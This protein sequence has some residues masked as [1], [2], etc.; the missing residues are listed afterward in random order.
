MDQVVHEQVSPR[1]S[2][3][4]VALLI[5]VLLILLWPLGIVIRGGFATAPG[6]PLSSIIPPDTLSD[7]VSATAAEFRVSES[8]AATYS[9]PLH[10]VPGTAGV[11]PKLSLTYS[12][13]GG[14]GSIAKGWAIGGMSAITRC[15]ASREAGDF[16][17][18]GLVVDG[19]PAP[20]NYTATD[21]YCLDGARLLTTADT[22][23][24]AVAGMAGQA[25]FTE[26]QTYRRVCAYTPAGGASGVAFFTVDGR[27]GSLSWYGDRD[28][29]ASANRPDAYVNSTASGKEAFALVWA[30]TRFQDST[31][32]YIDYVYHEGSAA[33]G[34]Q[35]EHLIAKV[36]YT[37]KIALSGQTGAAQA[38]YAEVE[39]NYDNGGQFFGIERRA[40]VAGGLIRSTSLLASITSRVD[41]DYNGV[42]TTVRHY[43]LTYA[44]AH[45]AHRVLKTLQECRDSDLA[46]CSAPTTFDWSTPRE[47]LSG[48][49]NLF[50]TFEQT[51]SVP[52]GSLT[53]FEGLK[54]GDIDGDGRQDM[55][56]LKDGSSGDTCPSKSVNLLYSRLDGSGSPTL[57]NAGTV[58]CAPNGLYWKPQDHSWF[59]LDYNGDGRD[60]YFQRTDTAWIG[61]PATGNP[62]QPFDTGVNLLAE[63]THPIPSGG[64]KYSEPQ[65]ADLNGDGLVDLVYPANGSLVARIMERGGSHG[66]RWG[67][68]RTVSLLGNDC[69]G[70]GCYSAIGL[71]RKSNY[72]Q[73]NDFNADAR[74]DLIVNVPVTC[75]PGGGGGPGDGPPGGGGHV[76]KVGAA[77]S[78]SDEQ[79]EVATTQNTSGSC[80]NGLFFAV[81]S[82]TSNAVVLRRFAEGKALDDDSIYSFSDVNG[83][84]ASDLIY[85]GNPATSLGMMYVEL[86]TG[87]GFVSNGQNAIQIPNFQHAQVV[88][89]NGDGRADYVYPDSNGNMIA[90]HGYPSGAFGGNIVLGPTLLGCTSQ[91]CLASRSHMFVD[92]EGDGNVDYMRV[93]WD[94]DSS[95]PVTFS[96]GSV[97]NRFVPRSTLLRVT[98]GLG[99][100]TEISYAPLTLK[101]VY[102]PDN[103]SR[104][105]L[106]NWGRGAPVQDVFG[107]MYV[108]HKVS[109]SAPQNGDSAAKS[110]LHYRYNGAKMQSGGRGF[111]GFRELVTI[112]PNQTGGYV[113]TSSEYAQ[114]FPYTGLPVKTVKR[115]AINMAYVPSS[116][117]TTAPLDGCFAPRHQPGAGLTGTMFSQS[118]QLWSGV[119]DQLTST[120]AFVPGQQGVIAVRASGAEELTVDPFNNIQ[121]GRV[122]TT[123]SYGGYGNVSQTTV[124]T[125]EG[126]STSPMS[127]VVNGN[128]YLDDPAKWRLGRLSASTVT[129]KRP[130]MPDVVRSTAFSYAMTGPVTGLLNEER[131]QPNG[132]VRED[133]RKAYVLDDYGNRIASF[134]CTQQVAD[135]RS[136]NIQY[137]MWQWERV[138]RYG[139]QEFDSRGRFP[140]KTYELFRPNDTATQPAEFVT[141][142]VVDRDEYGNATE[143]VGL[144]NVRAFARFGV[145]GRP[146][147]A[148]KQSDPGNAAPNAS[149]TVGIVSKTTFRWCNTGS[150]AVTCPA[151]LKFRSKTVASGTPT[152]WVYYDVL[153]REV[154][155]ASQTFNAGVAGKDVGA[156]CTEYDA[157][158]RPARVST[159]FF[160]A[161]TSASGEPD[162][163]DGVCNSSSRTWA[164]TEYDVLGRPVRV[165]EPNNAISTVAYSGTTTTSTNARSFTKVEIK[166]ARG[167]LIQAGDNA[168]LNTFYAYDA[169]GNLGAV[170]RDAGRGAITTS[171]GYD[172]LGRKTYVNDPDG[173]VLNLAYSAAGELTDEW[174]PEGNVNFN[175]YDFRG[176]VAWKGSIAQ[177]PAGQVWDHSASTNFDTA[178]NGLGQEHCSWTDPGIAYGTWQ[179]Q[180][181]KKQVWSRCNSYDAMGRIIGTA[182]YVDG[183]SYPSA[184]VYDLLGR[185]QKAQDPSGKWLKTEF[186]LRGQALR[187][188][189]SSSADSAASCAPGVATTYLENQEADA[190][191]NIVKDVRGGSAAMQQFRQYDPLTGRLSEICAGNS[192]TDCAIMRDRYVWD[193]VGNMV[194]RDR[195]DYGE[196]FWYD[197]VDRL[198]ISRINRVGSTSYGYGTGQVTDWQ[199]FDKL[200]NVCAHF[201]R[202]NDATWMNYNGRAGCGLN[203]ETGTV[204]S[205]MT[206]SP[207]QVRQA[208]AYSNFVYDSR[209]NQVFADSS[210]SDSLDRTIRYN[211]ESQAY[212]IFKGPSSAPN[213]MARFWYDPSGNRYKREDTGLGIVGTRR[214]IYVGNIEIVSENGT[215]TYKRYIGGVLVQDVVGGNPTNRYLFADHIGSVVAVTDQNGVVVEG[216][217]FNA[218][219]E[220]RG[221][222]SATTIT[223]NGLASTTRGFTGH[224]M[225]DGLD[226]IHMNGRI[227]DPTLGRFLQPDPVIQDTAN[228]QN[229][230]AY[231]YVFNNPYRY[232]DP[233]GMI[234]QEERR[235]LSMIVA[236]AVSWFAPQVGA[237]LA[238]SA[239]AANAIT[240]ALVVAGGAV[241]GGIS[242]GSQGALAGAFS[243]LAFYSVGQ[244]FA[245]V[246]GA[247]GTGFMDSGF[248]TGHFAA[249]VISHGMLSGVLSTVQGGKFGHGFVSAA[250][251]ASV[252]PIA[253]QA[254]LLGG[255]IISAIVGGTASALTGG[256]FASG[257]ATAIFSFVFN[258]WLHRFHTSESGEEAHRYNK[259]KEEEKVYWPTGNGAITSKYGMRVHPRTGILKLHNGLDIR[260]RHGAPIFATQNGEIILINYT[261]GGG[262]QIFIR[263]DD[264]GIS[265]Y[266][267]TGAIEGIVEGV[268]VSGGQQIGVSNSSGWARGAAHL[269]YTYKPGTDSNPAT[270]KTPTVSPWAQLGRAVRPPVLP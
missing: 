31:G 193:G 7:S 138:H 30:Q 213:R 150:G 50:Q 185:A 201:M 51:A 237:A 124:D 112:D 24:P 147:Y 259:V 110:T 229:W 88:D 167:E 104:N 96:R 40:Y 22:Q 81:E 115:A 187:V 250:A 77:S 107:P 133:L 175:R 171:M 182:T 25:Y 4:A 67:A 209:G 36:R 8:G 203:V 262:D 132:N 249:K 5:L 92:V 168:G 70:G 91:E 6:D 136:T 144:N 270:L 56:W 206:G 223:A 120:S 214:T 94:N 159:P 156:V 33:N 74:S 98:N 183:I 35:G 62:A 76:Q 111:L 174:D 139:R 86:N 198:E 226:V 245:G 100:Q 84:G 199:R 176:R 191:G 154:L 218:F 131:V 204:N 80:W 113:T 232:T 137:D 211:A 48:D 123:T 202:G 178:A 18:N 186:G 180:A 243:A 261:F 59:L 181:D 116:C 268:R 188:C 200:G 64:D 37:G 11:A 265:G 155:K 141:S 235:W 252:S 134:I 216:G 236:V 65:H 95:S 160:L 195:R 82:L 142:W 85:M 2:K 212:E 222:G 162:G 45:A 230:N 219:G 125:Y 52:N 58:F 1:L 23:C 72:Q 122:V 9:I 269:H 101:D 79:E 105:G 71:Y 38:P 109:S 78:A 60:D 234:G 145:L 267:H 118:I 135:C 241:S 258:A 242:G 128:A 240:V 197:S 238:A 190:F 215:T 255:A 146:Y 10:T 253:L 263:H 205:D 189:E 49:A 32:N 192:S 114:N 227:Y 89:A 153:G 224:E 102:R 148:W 47:I 87:L 41:H 14:E 164:R 143:V 29:A 99:A 140:T 19:D 83:D 3:L 239:T 166:N 57:Q 257:A 152:Q 66:F 251:S 26:I 106:A 260:A 157:V 121:T 208:N 17:A 231:T 119:F 15:R 68:P 53:K 93:K 184:I 69:P 173:G 103:G 248:S 254:G 247:P 44:A 42:Y 90:K 225:L 55:V 233:S 12:S 169:A 54:F 129:H 73:L 28:S 126:T 63:L 172:A 165:T 163:L 246:Q 75:S 177:T 210:S 21:R 108:V 149:G 158:G 194:W 97:E 179:G 61:Y 256:K 127:T 130:G 196:D 16:I 43:A 46:V 161:G 13:Q 151:G 34:N 217:G 207:H 20:V 221:N 39:F 170:T 228:P 264:G 220:R 117:L 266:A 244:A 27:D